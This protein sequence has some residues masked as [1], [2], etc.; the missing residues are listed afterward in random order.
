[1]TLMV[2]R[3]EDTLRKF[4]EPGFFEN[5]FTYIDANL[6]RVDHETVSDPDRR[7][8]GYLDSAEEAAEFIKRRFTYYR[9]S[10]TGHWRIA[11]EPNE[12]PG[13]MGLLALSTPFVYV[14]SLIKRLAEGFFLLTGIFYETLSD[15]Y[16]YKNEDNLAERFTENFNRHLAEKKGQFEALWKKMQE[17]FNYAAAMELSAINATVSTDETELVRMQVIFSEMEYRWNN[18]IDPLK[19]PTYQAANFYKQYMKTQN[20][21][22]WIYLVKESLEEGRRVQ[23]DGVIRSLMPEGE[24]LSP[25]RWLDL[26][27][28]AIRK[29]RITP[30]D[31][32]VLKELVQEEA[33]GNLSPIQLIRSTHL[34]NAFRNHEL[35]RSEGFIIYGCAYPVEKEERIKPIAGREATSY[36]GLLELRAAQL[37]GPEDL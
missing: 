19:T 30:Q 36:R 32:L 8:H 3:I 9:D 34:K 5:D 27:I 15:I 18:R 11:G 17:D 37:R 24:T 12:L 29:H 6:L 13:K 4:V 16:E 25:G 26:Q 33:F 28:D 14:A 1:M 23:L 21:K 20:P 7:Y 35:S 2:G 22:L 31:I 10:H